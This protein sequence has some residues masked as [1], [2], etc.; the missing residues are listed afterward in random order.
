MAG[1]LR[2][3]TAAIAFRTA[4]HYCVAE[5]I[6]ALGSH[7][8]RCLVPAAL[9]NALED[10]QHVERLDARHGPL[11]QVG[12][13][14]RGEALPLVLVGLKRDAISLHRQPF[15]RNGLK[16]RRARSA[17]RLQDQSWIVARLEHA[18]RLQSPLPGRFETDLGIAAVMQV[19][20]PTLHVV[21]E[22]ARRDARLSTDIG[23]AHRHRTVFVGDR[24]GAHCESPC[25]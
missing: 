22:N 18:P 6:P 11:S 13:D 14:E 23:T 15:H 4:G 1:R 12:E 9:L 19:L 20:F 5:D 2:R 17:L 25:P 21:L 3:T 16:G 10:R 24:L 7:A 8:M